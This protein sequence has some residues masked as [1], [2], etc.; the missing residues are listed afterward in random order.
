MSANQT[1]SLFVLPVELRLEVYKSLAENCLS[2]GHATDI[3]GLFMTCCQ[4]YQELEVDFI[5]KIRPLLLARY[6]W[7]KLDPGVPQQA[8]LPRRSLR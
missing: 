2:D 8:Y 3:S 7:K 4:I 6:N 1:P 5:A